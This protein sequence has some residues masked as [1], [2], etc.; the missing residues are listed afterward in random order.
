[1]ANGQW[2][3]ADINTDTA[4][5]LSYVADLKEEEMEQRPQSSPWYWVTIGII[6]VLA[7]FSAN[8]IEIFSKLASIF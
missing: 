3:G 1:M 7:A 5:C 8:P 4:R 2:Y 6:C